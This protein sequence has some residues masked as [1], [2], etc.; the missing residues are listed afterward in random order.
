MHNQVPQNPSKLPCFSKSPPLSG[1][2][3]ATFHSR[4]LHGLWI[5]VAIGKWAI[6]QG[7]IRLPAGLSCIH[8]LPAGALRN[9]LS[10]IITD[11]SWILQIY[12]S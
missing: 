5:I 4:R 7:N 1:R 2:D 6:L 12:N 8:D 3:G 9:C 11:D 10:I